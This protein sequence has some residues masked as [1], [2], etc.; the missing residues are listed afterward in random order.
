MG[1]KRKDDLILTLIAALTVMY[2]LSVEWNE[3][4]GKYSSIGMWKCDVTSGAN[5]GIYMRVRIRIGHS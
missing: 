4:D 2:F 5:V 3:L 1:L